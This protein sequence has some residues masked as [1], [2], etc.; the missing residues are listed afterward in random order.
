[1]NKNHNDAVLNNAAMSSIM[2]P[3]TE[4]R[5]MFSDL[6]FETDDIEKWQLWKEHED[7]ELSSCLKFADTIMKKWKFKKIWIL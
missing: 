4:Y 1:M 7:T 2:D 3:R 5:V 6:A